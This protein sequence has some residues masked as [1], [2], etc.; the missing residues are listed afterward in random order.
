MLNLV[1]QLTP[2]DK[3]PLT[4][5]RKSQETKLNVVV[6]KRPRMKQQPLQD[7]E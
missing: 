5:L 4:V 2:G 6:G 1:A 3:V 7:A